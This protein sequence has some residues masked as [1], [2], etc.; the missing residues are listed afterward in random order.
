MDNFTHLLW[1]PFFVTVVGDERLHYGVGNR[2]LVGM[3]CR[4]MTK[5]KLK[6]NRLESVAR[7]AIRVIKELNIHMMNVRYVT[8]LRSHFLS[9]LLQWNEVLNGGTSITLNTSFW[10]CNMRQL[11]VRHFN[12]NSKKFFETVNFF[13]KEAK[14]APKRSMIFCLVYQGIFR[15]FYVNSGLF[16]KISEGYRRFPKTVEDFWRLTKRSYHCRRCPKNPPNTQ[17]Y[18]LWERVNIK[19]LANLTANTKNYAQ[20]TLN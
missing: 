15:Y 2:I 5:W 3:K 11:N 7:W 17:Q 4:I 8:V 14:T 1:L 16:Q 9:S 6:E 12:T 19:K 13:Q 20:I 18:F 10:L